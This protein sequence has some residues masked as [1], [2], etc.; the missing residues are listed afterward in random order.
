MTPVV[1]LL[2]LA[3][4]AAGGFAVVWTRDPKRQAITLSV[5]GLCLTVLFVVLQAPDVALSELAVG[6]AVVPLMVL[7]TI[8]KAGR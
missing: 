4:V 5:Y 7:L 8:R 6:S 3:L 2:A 1:L